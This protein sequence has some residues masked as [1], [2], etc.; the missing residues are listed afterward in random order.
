MHGGARGLTIT[1]ALALLGG[2]AAVLAPDARAQALAAA[3]PP[4]LQVEYSAP[5]NC[6]TEAD[7]EGRV[8]SR[9]ALARFADDKDAQAVR[10]VVRPMGV[11]Y[12]G[13]LT[14]VGRTGHPSERDVEDTLCTDVVDALALVTALAVDPNA[15]LRPTTASPASAPAAATPPGP[16]GPEAPAQATVA[17]IPL[18]APTPAPPSPTPAAP[19]SAREKPG[20]EASP[21]LWPPSRWDLELGASFLASSGLAPDALLGGGAFVGL[22]ANSRSWVAPS[23]RVTL[24]AETNGADGSSQPSFLFVGGRIDV[25]PVRLGSSTLSLRP[26]LAA[27]VGAVRA[28]AQVNGTAGVT[29]WSDAAALVRARWAPGGGPWFVEVDGGAFVPSYRPEFIVLPNTNTPVYTSTGGPTGSA[30][31]GRS[32]R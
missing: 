24:F 13:H 2:L 23:A 26:C 12:A 11:T 20:P 3:K 9:T 7:F 22:E 16:P 19:A 8:R 17:T 18:L 15:T 4:A 10:V 14:I 27:D 6:P 5:G 31:V 30:T 25:C 29:A 21:P 32:F 1:A 28:E